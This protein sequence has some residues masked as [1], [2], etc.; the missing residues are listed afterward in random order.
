MKFLLGMVV[1]GSIIGIEN[2]QAF[3]CVVGLEMLSIGNL[4]FLIISS[5]L[6][7][8]A[9]KTT[10]KKI[11]INL[12]AIELAIWI[13][14]YLFYKGGY[15]TGFG[16][17]PNP[18]NMIYDFIAIGFR[19]WILISL[20]NRN[21]IKLIGSLLIPIIIVSLKINV[22]AFPWFS[23]K[24]WE[25]EDERTE[26]QRIELIGNYSGTI[27]QLSSEQVKPI[28]LRID[29]NLISIRAEQPFNLKE[30]Y[31]FYLEYPNS[32]GMGNGNGQEYEVIIEKLNEDSLIM[33]FAEMDEEKYKLKLKTER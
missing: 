33:K 17:T 12:L 21:K 6:I 4:I 16:G 20:V 30:K 27:S 8:Q 15:I 29:S 31:N 11:R 18:I 14:K 10:D 9:I 25:L 26:K 5:V 32:G 3:G 7:I 19:I 28:M 1:V 24:M 22:F 23:K 2:S 13:L